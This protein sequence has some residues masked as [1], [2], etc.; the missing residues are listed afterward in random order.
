ME[1][2]RHPLQKEADTVHFVKTYMALDGQTPAQA[3]G[4][5]EWKELLEKAAVNDIAASV[6]SNK[7][8]RRP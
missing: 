2:K 4:L 1:K 7:C 5:R 8:W 6:L 3:A